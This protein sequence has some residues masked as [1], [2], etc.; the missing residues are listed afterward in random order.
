M[1]AMNYLHLLILRALFVNIH[2]SLAF[3]HPYDSSKIIPSHCYENNTKT[4][5]KEF[6]S[7]T[8][9]LKDY[10]IKKY[11]LWPDLMS[12]FDEKYGEVPYGFR[13]ALELIKKNQNPA[14]CSEAKYLV[15]TGYESG[16]GAEFHVIGVGLAVAMNFNRVYI[17][18]TAATKIHSRNAFQVNNTLC[19]GLNRLN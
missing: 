8:S 3:W 10:E 2:H 19:R 6:F 7:D 15:T 4:I 17:D 9:P 11:K 16:F 13:E 14:D 12:S 5:K 18:G 1:N